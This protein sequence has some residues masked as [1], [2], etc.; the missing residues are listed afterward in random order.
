[1]SGEG[2]AVWR[3]GVAPLSVRG[4][5][6]CGRWLGRWLRPLGPV[7]LVGVAGLLVGWL[8][9]QVRLAGTPRL[10]VDPADLDFGDKWEGERFSW[11]L[12]I[13]NEGSTPVQVEDFI[14]PCSCVEL[15]PRFFQLAP[16]G[17]QEVT[18]TLDL[19][20]LGQPRNLPSSPSWPCEITL[21]PCLTQ[22][23][24]GAPQWTLRGT[25]HPLL[26]IGT[27]LPLPAAIPRGKTATVSFS[28]HAAIPLD[29]LTCQP[30]AQLAKVHVQG[31]GRDFRITL[32]T[33]PDLPA[34][35]LTLQVV[36][37]PQRK[38]MSL[39][40][41]VVFWETQVEEVVQVFPNPLSLGT[42]PVG[43]VCSCRLWVGPRGDR[44][45]RL[46]AVQTAAPGLQ[47]RD[48][49]QQGEQW[50]IELQQAVQQAGPGRS[51]GTLRVALASGE[52]WEVPFVVQ[53]YGWQ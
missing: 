39:P 4:W 25:I 2:Q 47:V 22:T 12:S 53:W 21:I 5:K 36:L 43:K 6:G 52:V 33:R 50:Q 15:K 38:G 18:L 31:Q 37:Q 19:N 7:V 32:L 49:R 42:V 10:T 41:K 8:V 26:T 9:P 16:G 45:F 23:A 11:K 35:P 13:R 30:S 28:V 14:T 20:R 29:A 27:P 48:W 1:M 24:G 40:S 34:G 17:H 3:E 46:L 51:Q 44:P